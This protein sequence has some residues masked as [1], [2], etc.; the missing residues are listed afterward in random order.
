MQAAVGATIMVVAEALTVTPSNAQ[1]PSTSIDVTATPG[2]G[3][4]LIRPQ[5]SKVSHKD[6]PVA[7][8]RKLLA[9]S[10]AGDR[11]FIYSSFAPNARFRF[12]NASPVFGIDAISKETRRFVGDAKKRHHAIL[13]AWIGKDGDLD[14][15]SIEAD[16]TYTFQDGAAVTVPVTS[17]IRLRDDL[18]ADYR[19]Y[20]D[21]A[22]FREAVQRIEVRR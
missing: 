18:I 13:G 8:A 11:D 22:P 14:V 6:D 16:V 12:G 7:W 17:T 10:D 3:E 19:I 5:E 15:V 21:L 1:S 2:K 4:T 20:I 9:A